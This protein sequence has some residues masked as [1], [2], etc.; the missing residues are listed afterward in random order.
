MNGTNL[1]EDNND[2]EKETEYNAE[3]LVEEISC[4]ICMNNILDNDELINV[5][6]S[7]EFDLK[8]K[9]FK[10]LCK[11]YKNDHRMQTPCQHYFHTSKISILLIQYKVVS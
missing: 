11:K 3:Q 10:N 6:N 1:L 9:L 8:S 7:E 4:N 5:K 2:H